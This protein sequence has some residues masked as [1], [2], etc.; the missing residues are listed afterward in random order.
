MPIKKI[1]RP[2]HQERVSL[3]QLEVKGIKKE[4][5]AERNSILFRKIAR[6]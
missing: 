2:L 3:S 1:A 4:T 6:K 5:K